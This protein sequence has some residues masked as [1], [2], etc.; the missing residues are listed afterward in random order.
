[1]RADPVPPRRAGRR[2][3]LRATSRAPR[4]WSGHAAASG[5]RVLVALEEGRC[6]GRSVAAARVRCRGR[7]SPRLRRRRRPPARQARALGGRG[8][9]RGVR[10]G[11]VRGPGVR[12]QLEGGAPRGR[13]DGP[14]HQPPRC[15][16]PAR[17]DRQGGGG[18]LVHAYDARPG[19]ASSSSSTAR[20]SS[21]AVGQRALRAQKGAFTG[22]GGVRPAP[23]GGGPRDDVPRRGRRAPAELQAELL[24]VVQEGT[25]KPV[26]STRGSAARSGCVVATNR[27][28]RAESDIGRF[29]A[30]LYFRLAVSRSSY[31]RC[32]IAAR[33][34][35]RCSA[36]SSARRDRRRPAA[37]GRPGR[38]R[39]LAATGL[40][41][42]RARPQPARGPRRNQARRSR[43]GQPRRHPAPRPPGAVGRR[44]EAPPR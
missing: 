6:S 38:G 36:T 8:R 37:R 12:A 18:A 42:Q 20:R 44:R 16:S 39:L 4:T 21:R 23:S 15:C 31:R 27:D 2:P 33:T 30:D 43:A 11:P 14:V 17:Q 13:R 40:P 35:S 32:G 34:S 3:R 1:M 26:G 9:D 5:G 25:Y 19:A 24:R 10:P 22:A 41:R 29:R 7:R 28:L